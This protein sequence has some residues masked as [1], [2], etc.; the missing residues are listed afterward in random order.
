MN[1][2]KISGACGRL[3]CCLKY[4]QEAYE[5]AHA[6]L[7][8]Q[9]DIVMTPQGKGT[10]VTVD[11][12]REKITVR[13]EDD[14]GADLVTLFATESEVLSH[15]PKKPQQPGTRSG[16]EGHGKGKCCRTEETPASDETAAVDDEI[17]DYE[18]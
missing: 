11:L 7:P 16:C 14:D 13:L 12:L 4:E 18:E 10:V 6:R 2:T 17:I 5:D 8:K 9:G 1:P 15:K 3:M